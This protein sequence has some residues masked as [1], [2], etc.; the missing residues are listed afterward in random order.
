MEIKEVSALAQKLIGNISKV[1]YGKEEAVRL[2]VTAMLAQG[3]LLLEDVPGTGKTMLAKSL[4]R[5]VSASFSRIQFTPDLLPGDMTGVS[6]YDKGS[7]RFVFHKGPMFAQILLADE[8]NRATPR[9][10]SALLEALEENQITADGETYKLEQPFFVIAT[11]NYIET[12][13]TFPLPEA[14]LDRFTLRLSLGYPSEEES[15]RIFE[16][17]V[18]GNPLDVI[19]PICEGKDIVEAQEACRRVYVHDSVQRYVLALLEATRSSD[20]IELGV[21]TRG[22]IALLKAA[23][24]YSAIDGRDF[25]TPDD[26]RKLAEYVFAHRVILRSG[27]RRR[28]SSAGTIVRKLIAGVPVPTEQWSRSAKRS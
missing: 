16:S 13:G 5:S 7:E 25:V 12:F 9:T 10:Q 24:S 3:H 27:E 22:G 17:Y 21:S 18:S 11:Q 28:G 26:V 4:A 2:A 14:Q 1:I 19:T 8:I 23:Q 6:V 20:E 15:I